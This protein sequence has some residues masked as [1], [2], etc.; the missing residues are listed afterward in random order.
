M[1]QLAIIRENPAY[2]KERLAVRNF[3]QPE[4]VDEIIRLDEQVRGLKKTIEEATMQSNKLSNEIQS[5]FKEGRKQE[6]QDIIDKAT[7]LKAVIA[8]K[9]PE[10]DKADKELEE[11]LLSLPN[12]PAAAVPKGRI[13]EDNITIREGGTKPTLP[14]GA[15]P[16]WDLAKKYNL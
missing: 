11:T 7:L 4:L 6:A 16:H 9:K 13:P 14:A 5:L 10:L 2:I 8:E 12:L 1:L 3:K 15:Q